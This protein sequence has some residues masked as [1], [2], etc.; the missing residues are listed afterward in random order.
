VSDR[1]L[2][3]VDGEH[4]PP[5]VRAALR[6]AGEDA[7]VVAALLLGG[8]EKLDGVPDYGVPLELVGEATPGDAVVSAAARHG[9]TDVLD[10]SDE[11]VL[12]ERDRIELA[13]RAV[14]AG[15]G[16]RGP[17]FAFRPPR[18]EVVDAPTLAVIGTGKRI[19]KT[20]VSGHV[21]RVLDERGTDVVVVAMGRGGPP[22]P[23]LVDPQ[24]HPV[25]VGDLL[26]R[27]RAGRHAASDFL[28]DAA[29]AR[30]A[31]VGARR[32]GGGLLGAPYLSNVVDAAR[33][34][35]DRRPDVVVLEGSGA[36]VPPVAA[37][38]TILVHPATDPDLGSGFGAYRLLL[39]DLVVLTM[40]DAPAAASFRLGVPVI[41]TALRP[42]PVEPVAG[43]RVAFFT[44]A[45]DPAP[46]AAHLAAAHGAEIV[47]VSGSLSDRARLRDE[48]A[49][50]EVARADV[51]LVEIK[52]AAID[53]VAAAAAERGVRI[54]FCDNR[55]VALPDEPDL[56]GAIVDLAEAAVSARA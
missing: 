21:A 41:R 18:R 38:R 3:L 40:C 1:L 25:E 53:V 12:D 36:A 46:L 23:E 29:L 15:L 28:E 50:P 22:E 54:V 13:C 55:P 56:D 37:D 32:C 17:D 51:Y 48:L 19:G 9:A 35:A 30:V 11:P 33:L 43:E 31:T 4:Y 47:A 27:A 5:V 44:T 2:A 26:E 8:S 16:Y 7:E 45:R 34:A 24:Q 52:A 39:A 10:L 49:S 14:A 6:Q 42:H 20:A